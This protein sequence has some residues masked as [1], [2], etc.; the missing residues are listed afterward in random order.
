MNKSPHDQS[1]SERIRAVKLPLLT[2]RLGTLSDQ[3]FSRTVGSGAGNSG[4]HISFPYVFVFI[5]FFPSHTLTFINCDSWDSCYGR[6]AKILK[7]L[8]AVELGAHMITFNYP[9]SSAANCSSVSVS[10]HYTE[11]AGLLLACFRVARR[12]RGGVDKTSMIAGRSLLKALPSVMCSTAEKQQRIHEAP[13]SSH[14]PAFKS[15]KVLQSEIFTAHRRKKKKIKKTETQRWQTL[16]AR[17][18]QSHFADS[19]TA[20][21]S[22]RTNIHTSHRPPPFLPPPVLN[23]HQTITREE[24]YGQSALTHAG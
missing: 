8:P 20:S 24:V 4:W 19:K 10:W 18:E 1:S 7:M 2:L 14:S 12:H 6:L 5:Y 15:F 3:F 13:G 22:S 9:F 16:A 17:V 21:S 23:M 11:E